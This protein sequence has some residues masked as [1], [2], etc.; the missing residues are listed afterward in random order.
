MFIHSYEV[1]QITPDFTPDIWS[2]SPRGTSGEETPLE[3]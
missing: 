3:Q 1:L 2:T